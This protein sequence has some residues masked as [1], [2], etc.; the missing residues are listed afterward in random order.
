M[1]ST[2]YVT[3]R[4]RIVVIFKFHLLLY[5]RCLFYF[6]ASS[7]STISHYTISG[8]EIDRK[9]LIRFDS[10]R[11]SRRSLPKPNE[12]SPTIPPRPVVKDNPVRPD[13][14]EVDYKKKDTL[15]SSKRSRAGSTWSLKSVSTT[16]RSRAESFGESVRSRGESFMLQGLTK[17]TEN[18][19]ERSKIQ[20]DPK[21]GELFKYLQI[22]TASFGAFA[23]GGND[24]R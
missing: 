20:D 23:H 1:N 10:G 5:I 18:I 12:P 19:N 8:L 14:E 7:I 4:G 22:L 3:L 11:K 21:A 16:V 17:S 15:R 6:L 9:K 2:D 24:V 13:T